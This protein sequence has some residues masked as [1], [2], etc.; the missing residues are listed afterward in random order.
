M[1]RIPEVKVEGVRCPHC[2]KTDN[3]YECQPCGRRKYKCKDCHYL[4]IKK[5][6]IRVEQ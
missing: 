2:G 5:R 6:F 4:G 1:G 3:I